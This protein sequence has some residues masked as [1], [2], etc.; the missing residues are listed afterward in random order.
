M[1]GLGFVLF[2]FFLSDVFEVTPGVHPQ[3]PHLGL[4]PLT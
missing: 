2:E 1:Q 3:G 4:C